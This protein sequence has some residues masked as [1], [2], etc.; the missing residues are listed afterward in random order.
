[1]T[2]IPQTFRLL[3]SY[4]LLLLFLHFN[5]TSFPF[6]SSSNPNA[7][8]YSFTMFLYSFLAAVNNKNIIFSGI[9]KKNKLNLGL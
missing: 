7:F 9:K 1:M 6:V 5:Y 8:Y 4:L 2:V 3:F